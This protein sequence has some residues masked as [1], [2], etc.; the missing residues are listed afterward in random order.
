MASP[1]NASLLPRTHFRAPRVPF[2]FR[3]VVLAILAYLVWWS[4]DALLSGI[5]DRKSVTGA[6]LECLHELFEGLPYIGPGVDVV[7]QGVFRLDTAD[8]VRDYTFWHKLVGGVWW[9][10]LWSFATL[11]IARVAALRISRDEGLS[12][13]EAVRFAFRNWTSLLFVPLIVGGIIGLF[14]LCNALAGLM[15]SIPVIGQVL[16]I[17]LLPLA[18]LSTLLILLVALGGVFGFPLIGAAAAWEVNGSLDAVS[19]AFSYVF[20]RPLQYFWSY[21]LVFLFTGIV[22][23][24]G[25]WFIWTLTR[26]VD[27]GTIPDR[28]AIFTAAPAQDLTNDRYENMNPD[29][30]ARMAELSSLTGYRTGGRAPAV[31]P[32]LMDIRAVPKIG[33]DYFLTGFMWWLVLNISWL[34]FFGYATFYLIGASAS[35]YADLRE[36]VDGTEEDEIWLENPDIDLDE[37]AKGG[38]AEEAKAADVGQTPPGDVVSGDESH[39]ST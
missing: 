12:I 36:D 21:F 4:G 37:M 18:A 2:D 17:V 27:M 33:W 29:D 20:A 26:T 9:I 34:A 13:G 22:L 31:R 32:F 39:P 35:I 7:L 28:V 14:A 23:L 19:R 8:A 6:F 5:F 16:A 38:P 3:S 1:Y 24:L 11:A 30:K 10:G 25:H 15:L